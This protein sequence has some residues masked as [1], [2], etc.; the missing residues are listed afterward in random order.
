MQFIKD[1]YTTLKAYRRRV[2]LLDTSPKVDIDFIN[3]KTYVPTLASSFRYL[4]TYLFFTGSRKIH[5]FLAYQDHQGNDLEDRSY[6][7]LN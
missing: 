5:F 2:A 6:G 4:C 3:K 7:Q 1:K